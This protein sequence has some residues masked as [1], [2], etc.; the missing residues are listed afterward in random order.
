ML[1]LMV[2][3]AH[4][5]RYVKN[6]LKGGVDDDPPAPEPEPEKPKRY[7]FFFSPS[8]KVDFLHYYICHAM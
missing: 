5:L 7:F 8:H 3:V 2:F 4:C 1:A 6:A